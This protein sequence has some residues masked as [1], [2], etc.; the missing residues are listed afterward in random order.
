[1]LIK[2]KLKGAFFVIFLE[3]IIL[4]AVGFYV[5]QY[6]LEITRERSKMETISK[7]KINLVKV[8]YHSNEK[9]LTGKNEILYENM[10][11]Y[12]EAKKTSKWNSINNYEKSS[13]EKVKIN[14]SE[15]TR[16]CILNTYLKDGIIDIYIYDYFRNKNIKEFNIFLNNLIKINNYLNLHIKEYNFDD[17]FCWIEDINS[18]LKTKKYVL[19]IK[20]L[21]KLE[22]NI[23]SNYKNENFKKQVIKLDFFD[24][25]EF[26]YLIRRFIVDEE[27]LYKNDVQKVA[28]ILNIDANIINSAILTE[29]CRWFFTY[30]WFVKDIVKSNKV[31]MV[32]SQ[33]SYGI[34]WI[35]EITAAN[36]E[37]YLSGSYQDIYIEYLS[38]VNSNQ[39]RID[40]LTNDTFV[41]ILYSGWLIKSIID[42]RE[43]AGFD[44]SRDYGVILTLYNFWNSKK[45]TP[46]ANPQMGWA[47]I[48]INE[49]E[50]T[51]W[52]LGMIFYYYLEFYYS[53]NS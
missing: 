19:V 26:Q 20:Q 7:Q 15:I 29:Q 40:K 35:K 42:R 16:Y 25:M 9:I 1:M 53:L 11:G 44:I 48:T 49:K 46:H 32:M 31:L 51:F 13:Y 23:E 30:R 6:Y 3:A 33:F 4:L 43:K 27:W 10:F 18:N 34:W 47:I 8:D 2:E 28:N 22:Q 45:K 36:I 24:T 52:A 37:N 39:L 38:G 5:H 14:K 17:K 41:Q 50:Y 12:V 21:K